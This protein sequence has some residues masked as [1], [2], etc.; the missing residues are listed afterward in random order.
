MSPLPRF[1]RFNRVIEVLYGSGGDDAAMPHVQSSR[2]N[3]QGYV[4]P[5]SGLDVFLHSFRRLKP[6][7]TQREPR[8]GSVFVDEGNMA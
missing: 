5:A 2:F 4:Q 1:S 8:R 6:T 7:T 3:V